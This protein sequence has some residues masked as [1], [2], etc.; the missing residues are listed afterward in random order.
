MPPRASEVWVP[1]NLDDL[2]NA[3]SLPLTDVDTF[4]PY[5]TERWPTGGR[6]HRVELRKGDR[7]NPKGTDGWV[8]FRLPPPEPDET[9]GARKITVDW[10]QLR[11]KPPTKKRKPKPDD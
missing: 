6:P 7:P 4:I 9:A 10:A 2:P 11:P 1:F 5:L 3:E 8:V